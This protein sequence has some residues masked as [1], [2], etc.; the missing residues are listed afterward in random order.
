M[1]KENFKLTHQLL[2]T[3][4]TATRPYDAVLGEGLLPL[5]DAWFNSIGAIAAHF[6]ID[7]QIFE[8]LDEFVYDGDTITLYEEAD[9]APG[10]KSMYFD[11]IDALY[12]SLK[13]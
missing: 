2:T 1:T 3:Y 8:I 9:E 6:G 13:S 12:E 11:N 10:R 5:E 7:S 4:H